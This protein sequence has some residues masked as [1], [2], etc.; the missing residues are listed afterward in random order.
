M[1]QPQPSQSSDNNIQIIQTSGLL[2]VVSAPSGGGKS[3]IT[4]ALMAADQNLRYSISMT[5]RPKRGDEQDGRDYFFV[6]EQD[7]EQM[8]AR[9]EFYEYAYVHG[10]WYGTRKI[11]IEEQMAKTRDVV[12]DI[13]VQGSL[14]IKRKLLSAVLIFILPPSF[15][16]LEKRLRKRGTDD[17]ATIVKRLDNARR[18]VLYAGQYDYVVVNEHLDETIKAIQNILSVERSRSTRVRIDIDGKSLHI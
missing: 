5:T 17:E 2:L 12:L 1:S 4:R 16:E 15:T 3:T 10:N 11:W 18:E 6:E 8:I 13:D 14:D 7:F 9:G